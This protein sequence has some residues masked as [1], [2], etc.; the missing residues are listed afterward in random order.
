MNRGRPR[1][2]IDNKKWCNHCKQDKDLSAFSKGHGN[3][4][5]RVYCKLCTSA[6]AKAYQAKAKEKDPEGFNRRKRNSGL[7]SSYGIN[8]EE[9]ETMLEAQGGGCKICGVAEANK[10]GNRY[11]NLVVDHD[12]ETGQ[13]RGLLCNAHNRA[14]GMFGD[15]VELLHQ[16]IDYLNAYKTKREG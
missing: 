13:V 5:Y 15:D 2:Y 11:T 16:A 10:P 4:Q 12:H 9:Y 8:I 3:L 1:V 14:L 6:R 7:M